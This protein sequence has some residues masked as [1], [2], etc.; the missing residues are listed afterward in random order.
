[1][2]DVRGSDGHIHHRSLVLLC[3]MA[4]WKRVQLK[5]LFGNKKQVEEEPFEEPVPMQT[6]KPDYQMHGQQ[7]QFGQSQEDFEK[8]LTSNYHP[9]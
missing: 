2:G 3:G 7:G 4:W 5:G 9:E 1:M 8:P 6:G